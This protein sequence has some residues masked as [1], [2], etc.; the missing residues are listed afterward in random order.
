MEGLR[1]RETRREHDERKAKV[2]IEDHMLN[3]VENSSRMQLF[4]ELDQPIHQKILP[5]ILPM[6]EAAVARAAELA[7]LEAE[8][9]A[10]NNF[11]TLL[12]INEI[13]KGV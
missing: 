1:I 12:R 5:K 4:A 10:S 11:E 9:A 13:R 6:T 2:S 7:R 8:Y 3:L